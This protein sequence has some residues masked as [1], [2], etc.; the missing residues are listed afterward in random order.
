MNYQTDFAKAIQP[1]ELITFYVGNTLCGLDISKIQGINKLF[2]I[3]PV[4]LA[5]DYIK[6]LLNLRG[7]IIT[8][9]DLGKR[10]G[11]NYSEVSCDSRG[12]IIDQ[13]Q[14]LIGLQVD[15]IQDVVLTDI[16][17]LE[18]PPANIGELQSIYFENVFK[19]EDRLIGILDLKEVLKTT[20]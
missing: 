15:K 5:P 10:L 13:D 17:N 19:A 4:S 3:T 2:N 18:P 8:I 6:G 12:I 1:I 14:E 9:I 20:E 11:L 7:Q 16:N